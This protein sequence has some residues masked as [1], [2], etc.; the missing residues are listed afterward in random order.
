MLTTNLCLLLFLI[1][2]WWTPFPWPKV[3]FV[4]VAP[5]IFVLGIHRW[6]QR[7]YSNALQGSSILSNCLTLPPFLSF[8]FDFEGFEFWVVCIQ[9]SRQKRCQLF[10]VSSLGCKPTPPADSTKA[11]SSQLAAMY[12]MIC[13]I[14]LRTK[15]TKSQIQQVSKE[16]V[17]ILISK[18]H[19]DQWSGNMVLSSWWL[20]TVITTSDTTE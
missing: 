4:M 18:V 20:S 16:E 19:P 13:R 3:A 11:R 7:K 5:E 1:F 15:E 12:W 2:P 10:L 9:T 6:R 14:R 8:F 17:T